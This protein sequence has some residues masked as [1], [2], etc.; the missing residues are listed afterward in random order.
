MEIITPSGI[1]RR[2]LIKLIGAGALYALMPGRSSEASLFPSFEPGKG[3]GLIFVV[4]DGMP[5]GVTRAMHEIRTG[6]F[7]RSD[8]SL[9]ARLRDSRSSVG[10]MGTASLSS[11][12]TDSAPA[13]VAWATGVKTTNR[14]LATLPDGR[15][16]MTIM[17]LLKK[18][19]YG[20]GLVTTTRATHATPAAWVS[21]Q[22]HRDLEDAIAL[23]MLAFKPDVLLGGGSVHFDAAKRPDKKDVFAEFSKAGFEVV[24]DRK[25]LLAVS[26]NGRPLMGA[27]ANS[28]L[29]YAVDRHND[30]EL[31]AKQPSLP[32]MTAAALQRLSRNPRGFILQVE[33]GRIDHASHSNDAWG[34]I[35]DTLELDDTLAVIDTYLAANPNTLVIVTSDHGNSGWGINGTGVDYNDATTALRSYRASKSS[36]EVMIRKMKGKGPA[37]IAEIVRD[38]TGFTIGSDESRLIAEAMAPDYAIYPGD[39]IYQPDATLGKILAHSTYGKAGIRRGNVG[40]TSCNHTAEDQLLL[41]YGYKA[42][43]LGMNCLVDNTYL[44]DVMC[45]YFRISHKNPVMTAAQAKP[46][47]KSVSTHEWQRHLKFHVA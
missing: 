37:D 38:S 25:S 2:D 3:Q 17:E 33:A 15:P 35:M 5:L 27:F 4:G 36:F 18:E 10:Y 7:G 29:A 16:L 1:S 26:T 44:F 46:F 12:V 11:I 30:K 41:A 14:L 22:P 34:A 13:S 28:H 8:S 9:Y 24:R 47:I 32:E 6:V 23:D 43:D 21:H 40:F 20:C 39:F 45:R 31:G 42:R 19:G